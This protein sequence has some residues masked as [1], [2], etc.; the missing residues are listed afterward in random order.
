MAILKLLPKSAIFHGNSQFIAEN[1]NFKIIAEIGNWQNTA[2]IGNISY[3][4]MFSK[5][6]MS[7]E[8]LLTQ[9]FFTSEEI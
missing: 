9:V 2:E 6:E 5:G 4:K 8:I 3:I 1:G 7:G